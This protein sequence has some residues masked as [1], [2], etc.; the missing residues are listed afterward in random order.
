M[1][2]LLGRELKLIALARVQPWL[3]FIGMAIFSTSFHIAGLRGLPRRV[4]SASLAGDQ[5]AAWSGLATAGAL[6]GVVL[7]VSALAFVAVV[8]ATWTSGRKV[9]GPAFEFAVPLDSGTA[10]GVWDRLGFW[11]VVG[12]AMVILAY[13]YPLA[14]LIM[15]PRFGSPPFQPF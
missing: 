2:R 11:T 6:G 12:I 8:V 10:P 3:W 5:G 1:P 14:T 4:Y 7:F 13:G 9:E 15:T